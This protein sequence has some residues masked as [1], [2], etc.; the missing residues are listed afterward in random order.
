MILT[1]EEEALFDAMERERLTPDERAAR[2]TQLSRAS[3]AGEK[4]THWL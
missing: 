3:S 1:D 2:I 4:S